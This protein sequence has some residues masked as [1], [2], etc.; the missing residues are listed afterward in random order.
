MWR[1]SAWFRCSLYRYAGD[2]CNI[3]L[4]PAKLLCPAPRVGA[5][6]DDA[7]L[8]SDV[9]LSRTSGLSRN[10]EALAQ[11]YPT[12]HVTRTPLSRSKVKG[13]LAGGGA[14]CGG[15]PHSL[16]LLLLLGYWRMA[17]KLII[18]FIA[19]QHAIYNVLPAL[20]VRLSV[21]RRYCV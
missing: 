11:R 17:L 4:S 19:R 3:K 10:R 21:Q 16:L 15:L 12:S 13:Q 9:C 6:S 5:L 18:N 7:R 1:C 8:T 2:K 14:Y 20:S